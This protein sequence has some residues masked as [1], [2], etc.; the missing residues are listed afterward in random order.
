[1]DRVWIG[2]LSV[3]IALAL[4][5]SGCSS[6]SGP[7]GG[8]TGVLTGG[9][10]ILGGPAVPASAPIHYASG[11]VQVTDSHGVVAHQNVADNAL[12]VF[13]IHA[14]HYRLVVNMGSF[15]CTRNTT[16]RANTTTRADLRCEVK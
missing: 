7:S 14:G 2:V 10:Q 15:N 12:Y 8:G 11:V 4:T 9:I 13:H 5:V 6:A 16:V 3:A 1:M